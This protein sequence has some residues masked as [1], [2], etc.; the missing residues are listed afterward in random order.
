MEIN[1]I[2]LLT[3][4][5]KL[6]PVEGECFV[7]NWRKLLLQAVKEKKNQNLIVIIDFF[8]FFSKYVQHS[9]KMDMTGAILIWSQTGHWREIVSLASVWTGPEAWGWAKWQLF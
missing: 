9:V 7:L 6:I 8:F 1:E 3:T 4:D 5:L 2:S